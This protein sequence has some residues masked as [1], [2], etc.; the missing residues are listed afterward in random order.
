MINF[1][2]KIYFRCKKQ[3][4]RKHLPKVSVIIPFYDEH[5]TT[6]IRTL[7]SV[8][9]RSPKN[10][11]KEVILVN[12]ASTK[13]D[14][15]EMLEIYIRK[16]PWGKLVKLLMMEERSGLIWSRL[17]G[18][19]TASGDVLLFLDC[20]MEAGYNFLPP[21]VDPIVE[22]YRAVVSPTLDVIDKHDY[23]IKALGIGR[24]V[25]DWNFHVQRI[26]LK[27]GGENRSEIFQTPIMYGAA[28]AISAKYFWELQPDSGL[29]I[30]GGD[31]LEMSLKIN[32]CGGILYETPCSRIAHLYRRFPYRKHQN[33]ID[34]KAR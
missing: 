26:P 22:N 30:Y 2:T 15:Y 21:L 14:L 13:K 31:Q 7:H 4:Y 16:Q 11:L 3:L 12:D 9:N 17:A 19:R 18:A 24:T 20:H 34:Y 25:F 28:F 27:D 8:I 32:L 33:G 29:K 1:A 10:V 23:A 5:F 6:L